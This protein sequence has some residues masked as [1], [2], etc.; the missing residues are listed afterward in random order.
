MTPTDDAAPPQLVDSHCHLDFPDFNG[1]QAELVARARAAGVTRMVTI[2]TRLRLEP[3]VRAI[4]EVATA[5]A[6]GDLTRSIAV[7]AKGEVDALKND[8][9]RMITNLRDTTE[10]NR[11]QDWLKTNL[12]RFTR[13]MQ[14]QRDLETVCNVLLSGLAPLINVQHGAI[15]L[16]HEDS[17]GAVFELAATYAMTERKFL[18]SRIRPREGLIGQCAVERERILLTNVPGDYVRIRSGLGEAAPLNIVALP[19]LF[20]ERVLAIIE[21]ASFNRFT[22]THVAFLDQLVESI[23]V[24]LNGISASMRTETLLSQSQILASELQSQ[25]DELRS[26]NG[27]LEEQAT[28][29]RESE[30]MLRQQQE[31][32][33][34]KNEE[35]EEKAEQLALTSKY[36]SEFLANM[37][38]ELR[39]PLNSLLILSKLLAENSRGNLSE[40]QIEQASTIHAAGD[41]LLRMINDIL[42][43]SKIESGTVVL[44]LES[45]RFGDF[46]QAMDRQFRAMAEQKGLDFTIDLAPDLPA[47]MTTDSMRLQQVVKNLLSNALKF[48]PGGGLV[49]VGLW[50]AG[51]QMAIRVR[52]N[53]PGILDLEKLFE[54]FWTTKKPGEGTGLGLAISSSIVADFGGRLTAHNRETGGAVFDLELPLYEPARRGA[55]PLAAE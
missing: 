24:V 18:A 47:A 43:L 51:E 17:D 36:K 29:M 54:P 30:E 25:Q 41:D 35:L 31:A 22:E 1:Q 34:V 26:S 14:G 7:E 42:D 27:R 4:A 39:T 33:R 45:M 53:G 5:V 46:A 10:V 9:N 15:W 8:I 50:R 55:T 37:S 3:Q 23:G 20:E 40:K 13:L 12:T 28:R 6:E 2:C 32:L 11:E 52:D 21:L 44:N 49:E 16:A 48:T 38:H 19:V